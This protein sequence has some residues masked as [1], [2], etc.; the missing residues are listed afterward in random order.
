M[1]IYSF[2]VGRAFSNISCLVISSMP[3]SV[4]AGFGGLYMFFHFFVECV[5][6]EGMSL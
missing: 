5:F 2:M 1:S 3:S 4:G 6:V